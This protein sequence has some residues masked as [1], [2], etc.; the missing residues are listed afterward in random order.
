MNTDSK[1]DVAIVGAGLAGLSC[2]KVLHQ[3]GKSVVVLEASDRVGGRV[4]TESL[5]G[6]TLDY[7]FQVLL[8]AYPACRELLDY[9]ALDLKPFEPG[10]LI[11]SSGKFTVLSDPWRA[12]SQAVATA[13]SP[14][15][16]F[17]DKL[18]IAKLRWQSRRGTLE[19]LYLRPETTTLERL[20]AIG[21]SDAMI[22]SFFVPFL[23]G[24]F[25]DESL[26]TSS[27]MLEFV[28]RM[29]AEG[30]IAVPSHGMAAIPRQL[31]DALPDGAIR[32]RSTVTQVDPTQVTLSDGEVIQADHVV[33]AT[34][35][36]AAARL[37]G[38]P[39]LATEWSGTTTMYFAS[40]VAIESRPMLMLRGDE[41]GPIQTATV[42]SRVAPSYAPPG[43]SLASVSISDQITKPNQCGDSSGLV[44]A[45]RDQ[46]S[47]WLPGEG[48]W[49]LLQTFRVPFGLPRNSLVDIMNPSSIAPHDGVWICGDF[50][51]TPSI[52]GAMNS[53]LRVANTIL[54]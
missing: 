19:D 38:L 54:G 20:R 32:L 14:V 39:T 2:A 42:L 5:D 27:R 36:N 6:F 10:A 45:V 44:T 26:S 1:F 22:K 18:R 35:S 11:R 33:V 15:G 13:M 21:F 51:E 12:P 23:G 31:T 3:R 8:T 9:D 52:Q 29:F 47:S 50:C 46:L 41:S 48:G 40:S 16:S 49:R 30:D 17:L 34:E 25:L 37:L 7:G 28:M 4:R 24:V 53:G 43:Q